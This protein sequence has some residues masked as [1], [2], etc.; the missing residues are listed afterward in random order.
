MSEMVKDLMSAVGLG[1]GASGSGASGASAAGASGSGAAAHQAGGARR[2]RCPRGS[3]RNKSGDCVKSSWYTAKKRCPKGTRR[4]A[5]SGV[6]EKIEMLLRDVGKS[7]R[8]M[9]S[10]MKSSVKKV[11]EVAKAALV[12]VAELKKADAAVASAGVDRLAAARAAAALKRQKKAAASDARAKGKIA[13]A[14]A[15]EKKA[16]DFEEDRRKDREEILA[17]IART[18]KAMGIRKNEENPAALRRLIE[19]WEMEARMRIYNRGGDN[20]GPKQVEPSKG[21]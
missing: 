6:C 5:K 11:K 2:S 16:A 18:R 1:S 15:R 13:A 17:K 3:R 4:N 10:T 8:Q 20:K 14:E 21:A 7:Q 9:S 19:Q 12:E